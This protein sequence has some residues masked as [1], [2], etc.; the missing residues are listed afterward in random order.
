[1]LLYVLDLI[2]VAVFA[3]SGALAAGRQS[4]DL[5]GVLV[6]A[7]VTAI[8]GGTLRD[9]LLNRRRG[10]IAAALH[11]L[12][13]ELAGFRRAPVDVSP[14]GAGSGHAVFSAV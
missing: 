1:M 5:L 7:S 12:G 14:H 3:I 8:G 6:I 13:P 10:R 4:L 11:R 9:L 2:G